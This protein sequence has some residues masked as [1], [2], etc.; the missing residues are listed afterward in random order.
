MATDPSTVEQVKAVLQDLRI[1]IQRDG[2]DIEFVEVKD[3]VVYVRLAGACVGCPS[4]YFTLKLGVEE[5][6]KA[7]VPGIHE[8]MAVE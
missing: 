4:S 7:Q 6:I 3:G 5:A 2:G 1:T 8:V